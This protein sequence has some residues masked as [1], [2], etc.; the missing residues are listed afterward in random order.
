MRQLI[1]DLSSSLYQ[2]E[3]DIKV[4]GTTAVMAIYDKQHIYVANVG[5]SRAVLGTKVLPTF[6]KSQAS[7]ISNIKHH[8]L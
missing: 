6:Q 4:S 1:E 2:E 8:G 7:V 3:M 5:D